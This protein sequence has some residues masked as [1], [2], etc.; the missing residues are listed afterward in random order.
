MLLAASPPLTT[1]DITYYGKVR[2]YQVTLL[3]IVND[4]V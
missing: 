3:S 4:Y 1:S 2:N